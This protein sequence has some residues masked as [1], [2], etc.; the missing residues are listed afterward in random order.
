MYGVTLV[1]QGRPA[2]GKEAKVMGKASGRN[3]E[4]VGRWN[5]RVYK[6]SWNF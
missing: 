3:K 6:D 1:T 4:K 2:R 5:K